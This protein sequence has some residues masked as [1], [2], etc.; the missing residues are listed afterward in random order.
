MK[1]KSKKSHLSLFLCDIYIWQFFSLYL[2]KFVERAICGKEFLH[3]GNATAIDDIPVIFNCHK[4]K[5]N[6]L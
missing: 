6:F 4:I 5:G 1:K 3:F 2:C